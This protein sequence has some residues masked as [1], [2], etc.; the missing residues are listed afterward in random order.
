MRSA[1][2]ALRGMALVIIVMLAMPAGI[3]AQEAGDSDQT[4]RFSK[5]ELT[6][7]LAPDTDLLDYY[8]IEN[9]KDRPHIV[10]K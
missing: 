1:I 7:M 4:Y 3:M 10:G 5:E 8:C 9:E 6:Q 2:L